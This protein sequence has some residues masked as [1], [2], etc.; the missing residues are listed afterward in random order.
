[1]PKYRLTLGGMSIDAYTNPM[2]GGVEFSCVTAADTLEAAVLNFEQELRDDRIIDL[3]E[4][5]T[6]FNTLTH[7]KV[8]FLIPYDLSE[9]IEEYNDD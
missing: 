9:Y 2:A 1:M 3:S 8:Q 4:L 5:D 6:R 7:F